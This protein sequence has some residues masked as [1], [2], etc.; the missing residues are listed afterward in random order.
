MI[1]LAPSIFVEHN[2]SLICINDASSIPNETNNNTFNTIDEPLSVPVPDNYINQ[3][4]NTIINSDK[5]TDNCSINSNFIGT[6]I[7]VVNTVLPYSK[8]KHNFLLNYNVAN[9]N[10]INNA[11]LS[12]NSNNLYNGI[13]FPNIECVQ[14]LE[15]DEIPDSKCSKTDNINII[16]E[17]VT[18]VS[19]SIKKDICFNDNKHSHIINDIENNKSSSDCLPNKTENKLNEPKLKDF[20]EDNR[21]IQLNNNSNGSDLSEKTVVCKSISNPNKLNIVTTEP[22]PKY[23]PT[24]EKAIKKYENKQPKKECIVM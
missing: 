4:T 20:I 17:S 15:N 24:V 2:K 1:C 23:T 8:E 14:K 6:N 10:D 9:E 5:L 22:F 12:V 11:S 13:L 3:T 16:N 18:R 21:A 19:N 7:N